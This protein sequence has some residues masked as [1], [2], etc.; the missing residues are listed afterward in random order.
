MRAWWA[1]PTPSRRHGPGG[2]RAS[3]ERSPATGPGP[4]AVL[5]H[6]LDIASNLPGPSPAAIRLAQNR[7]TEINRVEFPKGRKMEQPGHGRGAA[8]DAGENVLAGRRVAVIVAHPDDEVLWCG[9]L[10]L[11]HPEWS[12]FVAVLCRG[13]D[14]DRAPRLVRA[15][16]RLGVQG[17]IGD[18]DDGPDQAPQGVATVAEAVLALLPARDYDLILTHSALEPGPPAHRRTLAVRLPGRQPGLPAPARPG[19]GPAPAPA[20]PGL[21]GEAPAH[22]RHLQLRRHHLGGGHHPARRGLPPLR[23]ARVGHPLL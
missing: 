11:S 23:F 20:R 6:R 10:L 17:A 18:L 3:R 2:G 8:L 12:I 9:G 4:A 1:R 15:L 14:P 13:G 22:H 19:R 16:A 5:A 7:S 21:G